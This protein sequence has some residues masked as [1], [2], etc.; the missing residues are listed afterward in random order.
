M[1]TPLCFLQMIM[2]YLLLLYKTSGQIV[3]RKAPQSNG[4]SIV[5]REINSREDPDIMRKLAV[6]STVSYSHNIGTWIVIAGVVLV[7]ILLG[8]LF[9]VIHH[10]SK[11]V[12]YI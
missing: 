11:K 5:H 2:I 1:K 8:S 9:Y 10:I 12:M 6:N 4:T 7:G 3:I